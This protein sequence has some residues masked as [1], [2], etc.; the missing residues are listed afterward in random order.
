MN[1]IGKN[2]KLLEEFKEYGSLSYDTVSE[3]IENHSELIYLLE[4]EDTFL[5]NANKERSEAIKAQ[6]EDYE[7]YIKSHMEGNAEIKEEA[8][9]A[10]EKQ[11]EASNKLATEGAAAIDRYTKNFI[12]R[13]NQ[14]KGAVDNLSSSISKLTGSNVSSS[15]MSSVSRAESVMTPKS[16]SLEPIEETSNNLFKN[17]MQ[18]RDIVAIRPNGSSSNSSSGSSS[19]GN[20]KPSSGSSSSSSSSKSNTVKNLE[21]VIDKFQVLNQKID[22]VNNTLEK[23]EILSENANPKDRI[24]YLQKEIELYEQK[25]KLQDF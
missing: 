16:R 6:Q 8:G 20:K 10:E 1:K 13:I 4:D 21:L 22:N 12:D 11:L 18:T 3:L 17:S 19:S 23:Y 5:K 15:I 9:T 2:K 7:A 14:S 24:A 25:K